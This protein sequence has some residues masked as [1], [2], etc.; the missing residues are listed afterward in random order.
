PAVERALR[1]RGV[2]G[3]ICATAA[4]K[5]TYETRT[6]L[7]ELVGN[8]GPRTPSAELLRRQSLAGVDPHPLGREPLGRTEVGAVVPFVRSEGP[9]LLGQGAGELSTTSA[10][11]RRLKLREIAARRQ[12][13]RCSGECDQPGPLHDVPSPRRRYGRPAVD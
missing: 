9:I 6:H 12:Q 5:S 10:R 1:K 4:V 11:R 3:K 8:F 13:G 2:S 7:G